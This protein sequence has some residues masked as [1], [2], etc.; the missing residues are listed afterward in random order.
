MRTTLP[1]FKYT[2]NLTVLNIDQQQCLVI[3]GGAYYLIVVHPS[4]KSKS[5][6][7]LISDEQLDAIIAGP[8][9]DYIDPVG[10]QFTQIKK[11]IEGGEKPAKFFQDYL[12]KRRLNDIATKH[13]GQKF[14]NISKS[15]QIK[16]LEM[17]ADE[18]SASQ[19]DYQGRWFA[20]AAEVEGTEFIV[21][22][23]VKNE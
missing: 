1:G 11:V 14:L 12:V 20:G 17:K 7:V 6:P 9:D 8:I 19:S 16:I 23:Q 2:L 5:D 3:L 13:F 15:Q 22:V 10:L 4:F 21:I 18:M